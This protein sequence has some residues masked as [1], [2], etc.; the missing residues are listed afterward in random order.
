MVLGLC[1]PPEDTELY[2]TFE[3]DLACGFQQDET[4]DFNWIQT[5][6]GIAFVAT[7]VCCY[8]LLLV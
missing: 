8:S 6:G 1:P 4:D 3:D 5:A 7:L 2:C